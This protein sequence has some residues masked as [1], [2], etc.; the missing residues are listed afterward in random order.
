MKT[1]LK[2]IKVALK[3]QLKNLI[4][5][6]YILKTEQMDVILLKTKAKG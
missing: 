1:K 5:N 4:N 2:V 6:I 3:R